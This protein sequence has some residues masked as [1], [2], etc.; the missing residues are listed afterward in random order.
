MN[1]N[2]DEIIERRATDSEK[3][4][5]YSADVLPLWV[6]DMDFRAA[7]PILRALHDRV[8][9][10]VFGYGGVTQQ[11]RETICERLT[12]LYAWDVEPDQIALIPGVV[13]G[14]NLAT[15][16]VAGPGMGVLMQ[17]PV[18]PPF[19]VAPRNSGSKRQEMRLT[20][21]EDGRYEIDFDWFEAAIDEKTRVFILCNPHNPVGR[22]WTPVELARMAEIC[23]RHNVVICS[24][25][26]HCDLVYSGHQHTPIASL[27]PE[28]A[29]NTITL[30]SP[31]K[32]FN[33]P[34]LYCSFAVI[35]NP[36]LCQSFREAR[37]GIVGPGNLLGFA[38]AQSAY[39]EAEDW[40]SELLIYLEGNRD[41]LFNTITRELPMLTMVKPEGT[42]LAWLDCSKAGIDG[43]PGAFFLKQAK[44]GLVEGT[45]FGRGGEGFV[46]LNFGCPRATLQEALERM[47]TALE[48][49]TDAQ[50]ASARV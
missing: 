38:A 26:I 36:K 7:E 43:L 41:F 1:F 11:L 31:S 16:A 33:L 20:R 46:R 9:H 3:W 35:Q 37:R 19:L 47:K 15:Q 32:S 39:S 4:N 28:I 21:G 13:P 18:Y 30:M 2:F 24:D 48:K 5:H 27:S 25:E 50:Q 22:V 34:G 23:A 17:T 6:A 45:Q 44:V 42:Y 40:L 8:E 29:Q 12:R 49:V 14:L 10:G